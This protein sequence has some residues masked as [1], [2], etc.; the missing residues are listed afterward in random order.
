MQLKL[1]KHK[2]FEVQLILLWQWQAC[3]KLS[4]RKKYFL[5]SSININ[6]VIV[7]IFSFSPIECDYFNM[8]TNISPKFIFIWCR[9]ISSFYCLRKMPFPP[10]NVKELVLNIVHCDFLIIRIWPQMYT[11]KIVVYAGFNKFNAVFKR[12][13]RFSQ[14]TYA[15]AV[16]HRIYKSYAGELR[17]A[18]WLQPWN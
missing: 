15:C 5:L 16:M 9:K 11:F 14:I 3:P 10:P 1:R 18:G 8:E 4:Y 17:Q 6:S 13:S 2:L 12:T 7:W